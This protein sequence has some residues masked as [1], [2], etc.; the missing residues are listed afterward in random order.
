ML[1]LP[2]IAF[3]LLG[4]SVPSSAPAPAAGEPFPVSKS[5]TLKEDDALYFVD[6][7]VELR[8]GVKVVN[9]RKATLKGRGEDNVLTV[10]GTLELKAVTG[11]TV[12]IEDL[13]IEPGPQC[14]SIVLSHCDFRGDAGI[15]TSAEGPTKTRIFMEYVHFEG[16]SELTLEMT[17]GRLD[18]QT[19]GF[20]TPAVITGVPPSDKGKNNLE[21]VIMNCKGRR[22]GFFE[23]L[24]VD[25][26]REATVVFSDLAGAAASF[27]DVEKLTFTGNNARA[28][29][30][31]FRHEQPS[32]FGK[33]KISACD[34]TP[35]KLI[36]AQ[37]AKGGQQRLKLD[38][39]WFDGMTEEEDIR[40]EMLE[41][42][43]GDEGSG[44]VCRIVKP[45][46]ARVGMGG[47]G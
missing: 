8:S 44:V 23:G 7:R 30:V 42:G 15:R 16:G 9:L 21:L 25:G 11:G 38:G 37:P 33:T 22:E 13:W 46:E 28:T 26:V 18:L 17:G 41:D 24:K 3:A 12:V 4:V 43:Q 20:R 34:F 1:T 32:R 6:G 2:A 5:T 35:E 45:A 36:F 19:C 31:E 29:T 40:R 27:L 39:C 47:G 10:N 14:K